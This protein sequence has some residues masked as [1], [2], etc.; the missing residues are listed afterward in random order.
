MADTR[1]KHSS[2]ILLAIGLLIIIGWLAFNF[3]MAKTA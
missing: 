2:W 1:K 3:S